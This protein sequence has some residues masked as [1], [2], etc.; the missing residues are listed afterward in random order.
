M[1]DF[2]TPEL[3]VKVDN[4]PDIR[5]FKSSMPSPVSALTRKVGKPEAR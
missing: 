2:P 1:L 3:P 4:F 5:P